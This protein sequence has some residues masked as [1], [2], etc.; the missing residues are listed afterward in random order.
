[1]IEERQV[2]FIT[3]ILAHSFLEKCPDPGHKDFVLKRLQDAVAK[4]LK[5]RDEKQRCTDYINSIP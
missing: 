4:L 5:E 1:M 2:A 3:N